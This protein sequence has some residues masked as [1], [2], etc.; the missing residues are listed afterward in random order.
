MSENNPTSNREA[1]TTVLDGFSLEMTG[2]DVA[3]LHEARSVIPQGTRINVT[4]LASED[5][6]TRVAAVKAV[7]ELGFVPVPHIS[8]RRL[9]SQDELEGFLERLR[10]VNAVEHVFVVGGDPATPAGPYPDALSVIRTGLLEKYGVREVGIAGYPEGHPDISSEVLWRHLEDKTAELR[11]RGLSTVVLTQFAFDTAPVID[12]VR[13]A[14]SRGIDAELRIGVPGPAGVKRLLSFARRF[15]IGA[16]AMIVK[17]YGFSITNLL[18]TAGPD[19]FLNDLSALL[20]AEGLSHGVKI[21]FY[22]FGGLTP[23]AQW[24]QRFIDQGSVK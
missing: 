7:Q 3:A 6:N 23:T 1:V 12:W 10:E 20:A 13:D 22:A 21:H 24:A 2:K 8:A 4:Y 18:G 17:K 14:R 11:E 9:E 5:L 15:G 19:R 16:N